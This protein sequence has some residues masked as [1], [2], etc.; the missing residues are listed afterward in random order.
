[1]AHD[2]LADR[3][4]TCIVVN[5]RFVWFGTPKGLSRYDKETN[6]WTRKREA[7]GLAGDKVK[8]I[9]VDGEYLWVTTETGVSRYDKLTDSWSNYDKDSGLVDD[10]VSAIAADEDVVWFGT[11]NKGV[12]LYDVRNSEFV[13]TYTKRDRLTSDQIRALAVDGTSLWLGTADSGAQRYILSVN[14]W[15]KYTTMDGLPSNHITAIAADG[16]VVWFGTHEHGLVRYDLPREEWTRYGEARAL[17]DNDVKSLLATNTTVWVGTRDG[18][19]EY[20]TGKSSPDWRTISKADGLADNYIT[21]VAESSDSLWVGTPQGLGVRGGVGKWQF[22]TTK[23]GLA[24]N[25]VTCLAWDQLHSQLWVGTKAGLSTYNP[26]TDSWPTHSPVF[27]TLG[28]INDI[29]FAGEALWIA[30]SNGIVY[31][32]RLTETTAKLSEKNGLPANWINALSISRDSLWVGTRSGLVRLQDLSDPREAQPRLSLAETHLE[33]RPGVSGHRFDK[34]SPFHVSRFRHA[35]AR[36][37]VR[38]IA[39]DGDGIWIGTPEGLARYNVATDRWKTYTRENTSGKL[40]ANNIAAISVTET[41]VWIGTIGGVSRFD[42]MTELWTKHVAPKTTE[43]L[44]ANQVTRLAEDGDLIWFINW[45]A[46]TEGAIGQYHRGTKMFRFFSKEDLPLQP[47][48]P[49]ITLVHGITVDEGVVWFG[50]NAGMLR[51]YP[52]PRDYR[53]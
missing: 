24:D 7:D 10:H 47:N 30:T 5:S 42:K 32:D 12:S 27:K 37:N 45:K 25:F 51:Y 9:A 31:Y 44:R 48:A 19:N 26:S 18:L 38:V 35:T 29:Q 15:R 6:S 41:D 53:R 36:A 28:R 50:T 39:N 8:K 33:S 20:T 46:T 4:V 40:A 14:A 34:D 49:P 17:S 11:E 23:E 13:R 16:N 22:Y 1:M 2:G 21:S 43:V 3:K 52:C